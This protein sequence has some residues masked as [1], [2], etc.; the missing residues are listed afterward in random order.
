MHRSVCRRRL[1]W[2]V[3]A[4]TLMLALTGCGRGKQ[5]PAFDLTPV[6]GTVTLDGKPLPDADVGFYLQGD[7]PPGYFGVGAKTDASGKYTLMVGESPGAVPGNYKVT[8]SQLIGA[9]GAPVTPEEGMD[10]EQLKMMG[11]VKEALPTKYS[12]LEQTEL[13]A[14]VE[15]G[16][17]DGYDFPLAGS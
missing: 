11:E 7:A 17:A 3:W 10:V 16:K 14:A 5:G 4:S 9:N 1:G 6:S 2:S 13:N 12:V 8:V 15:K